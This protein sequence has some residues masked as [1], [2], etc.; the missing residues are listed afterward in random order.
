MQEKEP[1]RLYT[2]RP[3]YL[4]TYISNDVEALCRMWRWNNHGKPRSGRGTAQV[5]ELFEHWPATDLGAG[6]V[7]AD[8]TMLCMIVAAR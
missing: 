6:A 7:L 2:E 1:R 3:I 8:V 4:T 5:L